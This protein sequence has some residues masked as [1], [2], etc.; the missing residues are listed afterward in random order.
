MS[1]VTRSNVILLL[2]LVVSISY[3]GQPAS[4]TTFDPPTNVVLVVNPS[5][6]GD[7]IQVNW[8]APTDPDE[9]QGYTVLI[10]AESG[11]LI[12]DYPVTNL[13]TST[14]VGNLEK[15][16]KY[17]A[18]VVA[19]Y[20]TT[21][22]ASVESNLQTV[23]GKPDQLTSPPVAERVDVGT[24][25]LNWTPPGN[26]GGTPITGFEVYCVPKCSSEPYESSSD[27]ELTI[28][29]LIASTSYKFSVAS[30]NNRGAS[31][32]SDFSNSVF[33]YAEADAPNLLSVTA[34]DALVTATW[35]ALN[36]SGQEVTGYELSVLNA[37]N[38]SVVQSVQN[39]SS[40]TTSKTFTSLA[41]GSSYRVKIVAITSTGE[42]PAT[43]SSEVMPKSASTV[44][45]VAPTPLPIKAK[46]KKSSTA[47]AKELG[48]TVPKKSKLTLKV[49]SASK[50]FCKVSKGK[51]VALKKGNCVFTLTVQPPKPKKGK[52]PAAIKRTTSLSIV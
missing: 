21:T 38:L 47:L 46:A 27:T 35:E 18:K 41:N 22:A 19:N 34:G 40:S 42:S 4:A 37:S 23:I 45:K 2:S 11:S 51:L 15:G 26:D 33:P 31:D 20:R 9:V 8:D 3:L 7:S 17:K 25:K 6:P 36:V 14:I 10:Y 44:V 1:K 43:I 16:S 28:S 49:S 52:K 32:L 5:I 29:G 13:A 50:K 12:N 39:V 48:I 24:I 30:V